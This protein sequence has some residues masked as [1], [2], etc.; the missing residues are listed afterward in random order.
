MADSDSLPL[1]GPPQPAP[2]LRALGDPPP[3]PAP[4]PATTVNGP[5]L[6]G[7]TPYGGPMPPAVPPEPS[8]P[9]LAIPNVGE[10]VRGAPPQARPVP[11]VTL[12]RIPPASNGANQPPLV[13]R[14]AA[15]ATPP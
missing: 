10:P 4:P 13:V 6:P 15:S 12:A 11:G 5:G 2:P 9:W 8:P 7:S 1:Q 14:P 3:I